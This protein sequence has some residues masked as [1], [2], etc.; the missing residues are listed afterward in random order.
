MRASFIST[1]VKLSCA[2]KSPGSLA[3]LCD[4]GRQ[5]TGI[6]TE[7][8]PRGRIYLLQPSMAR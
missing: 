8:G 6:G 4:N 7:D 5:V 2:D 3:T 1:R